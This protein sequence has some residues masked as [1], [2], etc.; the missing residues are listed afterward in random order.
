M[1]QGTAHATLLAG[2]LA[3]PQA[4]APLQLQKL[5]GALSFSNAQHATINTADIAVLL[6]GLCHPNSA[7]RLSA[8]AV[9]NVTW[10]N[11]AAEVSLPNCPEGLSLS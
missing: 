2:S 9:A 4:E 10:L 1:L 7:S 5:Q 6:A 8:A 11:E 3:S